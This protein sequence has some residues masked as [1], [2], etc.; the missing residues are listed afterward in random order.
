MR[1]IK[2]RE[3]IEEPDFSDIPSHMVSP[4][5]QGEINEVFA[6]N[7]K[8]TWQGT[9]YYM[10]Y[11]GLFDSN[12]KEIYE[13]DIVEV[14]THDDNYHSIVKYLGEKGS[15]RFDIKPPKRF[16]WA[17]NVLQGILSNPKSKLIVVGNIY[18]NPEL[19]E[20]N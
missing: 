3:W 16:F 12:G 15:P 4:N 8:E 14:T 6:G 20:D 17:I 11:T 5:F 1:T 18:E 2:F 10:Q 9:Y 13:D 19:L 7:G